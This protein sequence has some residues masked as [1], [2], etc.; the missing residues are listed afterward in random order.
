M[1]LPRTDEQAAKKPGGHQYEGLF[2]GLTRARDGLSPNAVVIRENHWNIFAR[3]GGAKFV[4]HGAFVSGFN[5]LGG[6][7]IISPKSHEW[8]DFG[9]ERGVD[10]TLWDRYPARGPSLGV[11]PSH[12][13][14][15]PTVS[16]TWYVPNGR[17]FVLAPE[18]NSHYP[19]SKYNPVLDCGIRPGKKPHEQAWSRLVA[20]C[21]S[22]FPAAS[23]DSNRDPWFWQS[24]TAALAAAMAFLLL[25]DPDPS[26]WNLA[27]ALRWL[28]GYDE[29]PARFGR[30]EETGRLLVPSG[31]PKMQMMHFREM[32]A[33]GGLLNGQVAMAGNAL[34]Q[35]GEKAFGTLNSELQT[36][37][38]FLVDPRYQAVMSAGSDFSMEEVGADPAWPITVYISPVANEDESS[39]AYLRM[40]Y[41]LASLLFLKRDFKP[42]HPILM[43]GDEIAQWGK[44]LSREVLTLH[45]YGRFRNVMCLNYWQN[46]SQLNSALGHDDA[47][48]VLANSAQMFFAN[49]DRAGREFIKDALGATTI[50]TRRGGWWSPKESREVPL[51]SDDAIDR[52]LNM[53]SNLA[54]VLPSSTRPIC[55]RRCAFKRIRTP[56]GALYDG[57]PGMKGHYTEF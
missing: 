51:M 47:Q 28:L 9:L 19:T 26:H 31:S 36:K 50:R 46:F 12:A 54:Y 16:A 49:S 41:R 32:A 57:L 39:D 30:H 52:D 15:P 1:I 33:A 35:L 29:N 38:N 4:G 27:Y 45:T 42:E 11:N 53:R 40:H 18:N 17:C 24:P 22:P 20:V 55:V 3:N 13:S 48:T 7:L 2:C 43:V 34:M 25:T 14:T 37:A 10:P 44:G 21:G 23:S 5:R 8:V 6:G 56:E